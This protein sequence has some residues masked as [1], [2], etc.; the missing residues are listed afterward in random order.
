MTDTEFKIHL[1]NKL[2]DVADLLMFYYD[3][4]KLDKDGNCPGGTIGK[5]C[6]RTYYEKKDGM[7]CIFLSDKHCTVRNFGCKIWFCFEAFDRFPRELKL[8]FKA[9]EIID[10]VF[11]LSEYPK[12]HWREEK[13]GFQISDT[14]RYFDEEKE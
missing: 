11:A 4:C 13:K 14:L 7:G 1:H 3:P 6:Y 9:L 10:R 2:C 12:E 5:C 8:V